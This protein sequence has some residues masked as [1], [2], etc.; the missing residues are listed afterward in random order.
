MAWT[1]LSSAFGYGTKLT[2]A[3]MQNLRD[4]ITALAN[5][6]SGAPRIQGVAIDSET[7]TR[8]NLEYFI[9]VTTF[10]NS[11]QS[12]AYYQVQGADGTFRRTCPNFDDTPGP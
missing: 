11:G 6:D 4:N 10:V 1:D 8:S 9:A 2:S 5:G 7:V 12:D 3:Q